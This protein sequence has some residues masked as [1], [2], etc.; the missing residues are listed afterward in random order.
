M[1]TPICPHCKRPMQKNIE[2]EASTQFI[3]ACQGTIY[4]VNI[5]KGDKT[6][7]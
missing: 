3:C 4:H 7:K 2:N 6:R 1:E 5:H